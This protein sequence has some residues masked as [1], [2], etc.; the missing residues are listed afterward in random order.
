MVSAAQL[1]GEFDQ[2]AP[3]GM[4]SNACTK[5]LSGWSVGMN[6]YCMPDTYGYRFGNTT[7]Y[8]KALMQVCITSTVLQIVISTNF[9][10]H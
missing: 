7:G 8:T 9:S 3:C 5:T 4:T 10:L 2:P 6:G 1:K